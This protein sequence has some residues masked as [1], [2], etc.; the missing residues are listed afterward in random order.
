PR[1]ARPVPPPLARAIRAMCERQELTL[2]MFFAGTFAACLHHLAGQDEIVIGSPTI[3]RSRPETRG[4]VGLFLNTLLLCYRFDDRVAIGEFLN[5][6][7]REL[8]RDLAN[9]EV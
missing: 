9:A 5:G 8:L 6:V 4:V 7:K 2:F 1:R 3:E